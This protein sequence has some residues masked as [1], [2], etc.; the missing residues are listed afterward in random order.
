MAPAVVQ[1]SGSVAGAASTLSTVPPAAPS[2]PGLYTLPQPALWVAFA[3]DDE[4]SDELLAPQ[5]PPD[6][7]KTC[8]GVGDSVARDGALP[9]T[10]VTWPPSRVFAAD[11]VDEDSEEE[12][13]PQTPP[14]TKTFNTV[15]VMEADCATGEHDGWQ[16]VFVRRGPRRPALPAPSI[17]RRP[18]P[19]WLKGRCCRC[20]APGHRATVYC[21]AF[22]C[23]RCLENGHRARVCRD[24]WRPL[25][26]LAGHVASLPCQENAPHRA[27]VEVSFPPTVSRHR[28]W[29][30]I[31]AAPTPVEK[32][33][34]IPVGNCH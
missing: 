24:A 25:S 19:A 18:V 21:D 33:P 3:D 12:L 5:T 26:L 22:R 34:I 4:D 8:C 7:T 28:S 1:L 13:V 10:T 11:N 31:V 15:V 27:Q 23:S 9:L 2:P 32:G 17:A 6:V 20:L 14:A 16:E 29:A 30:S